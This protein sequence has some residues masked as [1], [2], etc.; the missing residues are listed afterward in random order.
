MD[1]FSDLEN[2]ASNSQPKFVKSRS[3]RH[4]VPPLAFWRNQNK[5]CDASG[6]FIGITEGTQ[7]QTAKNIPLHLISTNTDI[8]IEGVQKKRKR[9]NTHIDYDFY[10]KKSACEQLPQ[11]ILLHICDYLNIRDLCSLSRV[12]I[13]WNQVSSD[14]SIWS[15]HYSSEFPTSIPDGK[16]ISWKQ[17]F[18]ARK[19]KEK[20]ENDLIQLWKLSARINHPSS[21]VR[22]VKPL[23][24]ITNTTNTVPSPQKFSSSFST[25]RPK[26][27]HKTQHT[28]GANKKLKLASNTQSTCISEY[29]KKQ[30]EYFASLDS[31]PLSFA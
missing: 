30:K 15:K 18:S 14:N 26:K 8:A 6:N 28:K 17:A 9:S 11:E 10:T 16:H 19:I 4:I 13:V 24:D 1:N 5:M 3:G 21:L 22:K 7:E 29:M 23:K 12:C 31:E 27:I 20:E 25:E 2:S